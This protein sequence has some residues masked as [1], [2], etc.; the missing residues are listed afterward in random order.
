MQRQPA[1]QPLD[2]ILHFRK[3][4]TLKHAANLF[5]KHQRANISM[6]LSLSQGQEPMEGPGHSHAA[7]A[8][9]SKA[10][11]PAS[12]K[13][14]RQSFFSANKRP[15]DAQGDSSQPNK[16]QKLTMQGGARKFYPGS[17]LTSTTLRCMLAPP[18]KGVAVCSSSL[19][20][21]DGE[22]GH[23]VPQGQPPE[24]RQQNS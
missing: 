3:S 5:C 9:A 14:M 21:Q 6:A 2:S 4:K 18:I 1:G 20:L 10:S 13:V 12:N 22:M 11:A 17:V 19:Y 7:A 23:Q 16:Q 8:S 15:N 24:P